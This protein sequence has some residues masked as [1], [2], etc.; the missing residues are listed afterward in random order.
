M[1]REIDVIE[2]ASEI[3]QAVKKGV[4]V[5]TKADGKVNAMTIGWG[6]L[7]IEWARPIFTT[8][9]RENRFTCHNLEKNGEFTVSIPQDDS[10]K[11][12]LGYCGSRSGR[13]CDKIKELKLTLE[14]PEIISVPAIRELPLT[15]EC[16]VVYKQ[17]QDERALSAEF[18]KEFYPQDVDSSFH[19]ANK[20][21]HIAYY[22]EIVK[23]YVIE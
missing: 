8:F 23:A 7:G 1:K 16:R 15:L 19:G 3:M 18:I 2:H 5:V 11:K 12:I 9:I 10:A 17:K 21:F 20:D 13:E 22:G 4:L 6:T 14:A